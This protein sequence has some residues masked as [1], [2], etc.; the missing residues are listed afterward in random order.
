[1]EHK[2]KKQ[3]IL[4]IMLLL[5]V[6]SVFVVY[7]GREWMF[8]NPFKPYTFS[9]VSYASGDG[10]GCTYVIDDSNRK[11]LKISADGRLLWRACASD[12]SFL[13]AERVVAD[14]DGN[15]YLHDVRI[16]QGVQIASE[17]IVKLSSKGKYISTVASVEAEK[18]SVRRNIVGMV[19][20]E[21]GVIYMQKEKEGILVSNTEQGS[22]KVFSVADA[23]DRILCCAYDRDSDSL[24]YVTYDGKI[25]KYTDSGQDEEPLKERE[26][27]YH[28]SA[29]GILVSS[30]NY[31][32]I[33]WDGEDY[34]QFWDVPL[35]GKLQVW[36]CLLW[37][38]CAVIV[39]AVLFFAVTL[40]K[41]LVKKFS[42]YAKITMAV[43]GIIVGVAALFIG[44]L[45]PQFQ[46]LLVDETYTREKFA[47]SAVTNR[48]PADAFQRL[49][50]PSDFMNEDYRQVRQVVR[51]V[52]F[53]DSDSSQD[54]YCV[55]YKV[56]D[57]T[58]TLVYTL[59]DIC[60]SY[61]YDWEYEGTDL[62]EVMEQGATKTYATNSSSGSF[63]FIHSP[64]RDKS[65]DI[66]GII[67]VGTDMNSLTE[68]SREIQVSL[69]INLIAIMVVFFMLTFE[70]IYFIKGRQELKRRKQEEDN[71]R[72]PVEI[73]RFIVFLVFFFTNLTCAILPIYAMKISEK[74]SVQGLSPAMLAAVP[75]SAEVL[76][77]AIFSALGGKVIHKLGAKRSVFVSSVLLTAG[78]GLRV[79]PNIWL[80]TLSALLLGAGWGVLL[81]LVNLMIVELPDE[82]KN[83]AYAYYSVSSLSGANCAVVFGGFL[84][85]WM[86]YTALFAVTA[87]LSVLLFLVANKYM[88]KY[89]SDNEEENCETED[90]H[91][92]IVQFIFRPRI[93]SFFLLMMIPLLIC[94]YFLN[95]MFPIVGSEWGLSETYIGYTYLLNGI[96]VLILGTPLTEFFSNR[97]WKHLGLAAAAFIYA[98]AFLE[99]AMLQNIPSLLIALAL[100]G[101][102]DSFGI[103]LLTSYFTDLK[104][105]ERFGY[106]RGL[107]VY[108]LFENGAQSLG[109]FVF[110]Y[111]LVLG[112][113]RGL[114]FVL[115]L[116]SVLSAAFLISTTFAAHRDKKGGQR[117]WK[118]DES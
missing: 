24:F 21:H 6:C 27:A 113:G 64:I 81:L 75:I 43:I 63:V 80:L 12:K 22:S 76:S 103:P 39:A 95:Y 2:R 85:Q 66:I 115:I 101:V 90:T 16:E 88:S 74:M 99:V 71:S 49:E 79:V 32:V 42:F 28:V 60:V 48:L 20:T 92:N 89:T 23:Q 3:W 83:R 114:I 117:A 70:V 46:S 110:G 118:K 58:V 102:A 69:I 54:L 7:A 106:D 94:G 104:D 29:P 107:G 53:S 50:K 5:T 34:E 111:V 55:L 108:S 87:V 116:V 98:A 40:L 30:T 73:F 1:M 38:A 52:F 96:F 86:S 19:P 14:G 82:E 105:V 44:T 100:I 36:N 57:G 31:S 4:I 8:T 62:Q 56:K 97:G 33:L 67:E 9:S 13:S 112:V 61:P 65:G 26:I 37:A 47:A 11:I 77:G 84:L 68:K 91:M 59:E 18:G 109:S 17:G 10:D 51:D 72:L 25:Y 45:F 35:S 93:I 78:L 15:V 41:I